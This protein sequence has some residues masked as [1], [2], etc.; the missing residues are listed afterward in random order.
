MNQNRKNGLKTLILGEE[1]LK[2]PVFFPKASY[3]DVESDQVTFVKWNFR[4]QS[5]RVSRVQAW[6]Q[7]LFISH[8]SFLTSRC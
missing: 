5:D 8:F 4:P 2:I 7:V 3:W 1:N 6:P